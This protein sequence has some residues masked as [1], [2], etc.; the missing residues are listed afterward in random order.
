MDFEGTIVGIFI[1]VLLVLGG[2]VIGH[3]LGEDS[4]YEHNLKT[5][6]AHGMSETV[7]ECMLSDNKDSL[8]CFIALGGMS[9]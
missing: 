4:M 1:A 7:A 6:K 5:L 3:D 2:S 8:K 9:K